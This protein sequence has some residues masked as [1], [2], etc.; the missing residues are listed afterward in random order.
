MSSKEINRYA[1]EAKEPSPE[2]FIVYKNGDTLKGI[3]LK[4][5]HNRINGKI[6]W[7]LDGK[8]V[9]LDNIYCYQDKYGYRLKG[10]G[11]II[12]GKMNMYVDRVDNSSMATYHSSTN[13]FSQQVS[14]ATS[15]YMGKG[16][17][18]EPI[19]FNSITTAMGDCPAASKQIVTEFQNT[20][21]KKR[22]NIA[23]NDYRALIRIIEIYNNC[24]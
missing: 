13:S 20:V 12:K 8:S 1:L 15:F 19:T 14:T 2:I 11:R 10:V 9:P 18:I 3:E 5:K 4:K 17:Y 7:L 23:I 21:W 6:T 16:E 22:P 24:F